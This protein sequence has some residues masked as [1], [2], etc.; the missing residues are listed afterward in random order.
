MKQQQ[1]GQDEVIHAHLDM[2]I[3]TNGL[4]VQHGQLKTL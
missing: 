4:S 3:S 2:P 1:S